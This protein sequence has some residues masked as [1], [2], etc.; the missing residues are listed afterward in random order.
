A[1]TC[2]SDSHIPVRAGVPGP[3]RAFVALLPGTGRRVAMAHVDCTQRR[4]ALSAPDSETIAAAARL[5][6]AERLPLVLVLASSGVDA[7]EGVAAL[8]GWGR[9]ARALADC[10]GL[11]PTVVVAYGLALSGPALLLGMAD[12]VVM[13]ADAVAYVSGPGAVAEL[14]DV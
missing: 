1:A 8:D 6:Q 3:A 11:V 4:G 14:T 9:A 5:A 13:T 10:S 12:L 7:H 2:R